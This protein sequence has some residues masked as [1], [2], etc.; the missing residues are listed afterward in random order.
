[1]L[2]DEQ[3]RFA[4]EDARTRHE[5]VVSLLYAN[6][7]TAMSLLSLYV[8][9]GLATVT[10][11]IATLAKDSVVPIVFAIPLFFVTLDFALGS[12]FCL[13]A[14]KTSRVNM[15]GR[16]PDFWIWASQ[17]DV[18]A[19]E[20][21]QQYLENLK[22]KRALNDDVNRESSV[23]LRRAKLCEAGAPFVALAAVLVMEGL[24]FV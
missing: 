11:F 17:K 18:T 21:Y 4:L 23:Q 14:V 9:L 5:A 20:S 13:A 15:P 12:Y 22:G 16:N 10:G 2:T 6:D 19:E 24:K 8:T 7:Q 1:M 3:W